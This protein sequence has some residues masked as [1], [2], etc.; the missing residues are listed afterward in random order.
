MDKG[1]RFL[2]N[3]PMTEKQLGLD[4]QHVI[5]DR[6]AWE[7]AR[8]Q[9]LNLGIPRVS[10][11]MLKSAIRGAIKCSCD[12]TYSDNVEDWNL[13]EKPKELIKR[14]NFIIDQYYR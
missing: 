3:H 5:V 12:G 8:K 13:V 2:H 9:V 7:E 4:E 10:G 6:D 1:H 14:I 11:S